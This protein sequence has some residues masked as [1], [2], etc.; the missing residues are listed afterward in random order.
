MEKIRVK[1]VVVGLGYVGV[2]LAVLLSQQNEVTAIDILE[3]KV[4][5]INNRIS[6]IQDYEIQEFMNNRELH[7]EAC[8]K[9]EGVYKDADYVII[10]T[11]TDYNDK[12][13]F[14]DTCTVETVLSE[15]QKENKCA[16]IVIKS[17]VPIGFTEKMIELYN[18][19]KIIFSPEFLR[20]GHALQDNLYPSRIVIGNKTRYGKEFAQLLLDAAFKKDIS[21]LYVGATE[22]EAIKLF[23]NTYLALRVAF[24]NELDTYAE[25]KNLN[26]KEIVNGV[27]LDERIGN[28]YNNPSFGY[29]GYCLPKDSKQLKANYRDIPQNLISA[30]VNSNSTRKD[31]IADQIVKKNSQVVGIYRLTM[32]TDSD[33]YRESSVQGIVERIKEKVDTILIYEPTCKEERFEGCCVVNNLC[34]FKERADII[35]ANR[36]DDL[37]EDVKGKVYTRDLFRRD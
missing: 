2:S 6:P 24:F 7:L 31:F 29:G 21:V 28:F 12:M 5:K 23:S 33:N 26:A 36:Y 9:Y 8:L 35:V 22:A 16:K 1:I 13:Q 18:T 3:D 19:D 30:I 17:T 37:L 32:K 20:E 25:M 34:E 27:C 10:A 14:F 15:I 11:P 4:D